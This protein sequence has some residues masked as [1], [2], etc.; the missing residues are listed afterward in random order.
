M[1]QNEWLESID[2][3]RSMAEKWKNNPGELWG[4][5]TGVNALDEVTG[6]ISPGDL[7]VIAARSSHG[8]SALG[9]QIFWRAVDDIIAGD[10]NEQ[11]VMITPEMTGP[12]VQLRYLSH[13]T[14]YN[15]LDVRR[16]FLSETEWQTWEDS[17]DSLEALQHIVKIHT[18]AM[19]MTDIYDLVTAYHSKTPVRMVLI[20]YLQLLPFKG[21]RYGGIS[22]NARIAKNMTNDLQIPVILLSQVRKLA[23]NA[24]GEIDESQKPNVHEVRDSG[25]I[26]EAADNVWMLW[27]DLMKMKRQPGDKV[28]SQV[29]VAKSRN[30]ELGVCK[31]V[32]NPPITRF[33]DPPEKKSKE[34]EW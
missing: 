5:S 27:T 26:V 14:G 10:L 21:D 7:T 28:M 1:R 3:L 20:D 29:D 23:P 31:L 16:G 9:N 25:Q 19:R 11:V 34:V 22:D 32:F 6:G 24:E 13:L 8:K 12:Q 17:L 2:T 15:S 4:Y 18:P 33:E 30:A